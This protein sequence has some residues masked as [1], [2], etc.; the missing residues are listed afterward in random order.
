MQC[1]AGDCGHFDDKGNIYLVDR[2]K[3]LLKYKGFQ[4]CFKRVFCLL[5]LFVNRDL[6][7]K[8]RIWNFKIAYV[9]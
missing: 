7:D 2:I 1:G 9:F 5:K 4:A 6:S 8:T 3:D